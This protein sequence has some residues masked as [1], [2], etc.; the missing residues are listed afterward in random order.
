MINVDAR[1]LHFFVTGVNS[2][3]TSYE[4]QIAGNVRKPATFPND[5][6]RRGV[7]STLFGAYASDIIYAA[8]SLSGFGPHSYGPYAMT[9]HEVAISQ[10]ATVLENNSFDFVR[11]HNLVPGTKRPPAFLAA[12]VSRHK[13]AVAKIAP[14]ITPQTRDN[15]FPQ[16]L[17]SSSGNRRTDEFIE[18][19]I[20]GPFDLR[21]VKSV[22]GSSKVG[23]RQDR[24]LLRIIKQYL[25]AAGIT[26]I[27][28][29]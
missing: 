17:L 29:D 12:W 23:S 25:K 24:D 14:Y 1:F 9:L 2:L 28:H 27:E 3:Y 21:A 20:Y 8:L 7:G 22:S 16:L 10:R 6:E 4:R 26:W 19:Q 15:D 11:K 13:L 5:A 18:V